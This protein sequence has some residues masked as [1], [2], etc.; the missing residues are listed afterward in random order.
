MAEVSNRNG[1][2]QS[3]SL[4]NDAKMLGDSSR[5]GRHQQQ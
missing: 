2:L 5:N 4:M 3:L 1:T